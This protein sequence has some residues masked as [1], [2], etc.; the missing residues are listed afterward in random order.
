MG[1]HKYFYISTIQVTNIIE[2]TYIRKNLSIYAQRFTY[3]N[4]KVNLN[5]Y[6]IIVFNYDQIHKALEYT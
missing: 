3:L 5:T 2:Y 4:M 1:I 6:Y